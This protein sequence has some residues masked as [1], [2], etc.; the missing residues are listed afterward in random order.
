MS[1][2]W[3]AAASA[4]AKSL[5]LA[6]ASFFEGRTPNQSCG[7]GNYVS[8]ITELGMRPR[9]RNIRVSAEL[10]SSSDC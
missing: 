4:A 10:V 2:L 6:I 7:S 8:P 5:I 9:P 1:F 3:A